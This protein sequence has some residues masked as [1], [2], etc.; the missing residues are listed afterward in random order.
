MSTVHHQH[1]FSGSCQTLHNIKMKDDFIRCHLGSTPSTVHTHLCFPTSLLS[2][3]RRS[4]QKLFC[5]I[6]IK[7]ISAQFPSHYKNATVCE[8]SWWGWNTGMPLLEITL[9][10]CYMQV[11]CMHMLYN[12]EPCRY[13]KP[14]NQ[15]LIHVS[16]ITQLQWL[17]F[18]AQLYNNPIM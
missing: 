3:R 7:T 16:H 15:L 18:S 14:T 6:Q 4:S 11:L 13:K 12:D 17:S 1:G 2:A 10:G 5:G 9:V 8:F